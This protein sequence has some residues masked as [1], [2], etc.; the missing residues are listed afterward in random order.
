MDCN[1]ELHK[2]G[3]KPTW[4]CS[5]S[6]GTQTRF[7]NKYEEE[8]AGPDW[9]PMG[10]KLRKFEAISDFLSFFIYYLF[11]Y[12]SYVHTMLGS[13]LPTAPTPSLTTHPAPSLS[14]HPLDTRQ[15]LFCPYL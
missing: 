5:P 6:S 9:A 7:G 13:F 1:W 2:E 12:Y 15:K 3:R 8:Y 14:P 10:R 4:I 11:F